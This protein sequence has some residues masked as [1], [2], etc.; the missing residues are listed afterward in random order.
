[1]LNSL[2][3]FS[4]FNTSTFVKRDYENRS[5]PVTKSPR[6]SSAV[7]F[8]QVKAL[9][10]LA[11]KIVKLV[12]A[13]AVVTGQ[14]CLGSNLVNC[15]GIR[16]R[17]FQ[18]RSHRFVFS[19]IKYCQFSERGCIHNFTLTQVRVR[20]QCTWVKLV[21]VERSESLVHAQTLVIQSPLNE[22]WWNWLNVF[23]ISCACPS[24]SVAV[25][26]SLEVLPILSI[27]SVR[28]NVLQ[29]FIPLPPVGPVV[30]ESVR[31]WCHNN[32]VTFYNA[33]AV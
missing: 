18:R 26:T 24:W 20:V 10:S 7:T 28:F 30:I 27:L 21:I 23:I 19:H 25:S 4:T 16:H 14:K 9:F 6:S 1:V 5:K 12:K 3:D 2:Q 31:Y 29:K 33:Y 32:C 8:E 11:K 13:I 15:W 22:F 17:T